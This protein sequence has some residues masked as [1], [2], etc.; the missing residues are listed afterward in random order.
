MLVYI[1]MIGWV[2]I[3]IFGF[4]WILGLLSVFVFYVYWFV[5]VYIIF[6]V[7]RL[8]GKVVG[9]LFVWG[10]YYIYIFEGCEYSS[11]C[12]LLFFFSNDNLNNCGKLFW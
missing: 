10:I 1:L 3:F 5:F 7:L 11:L 2:S 6:F 9:G 8:C 12:V 4:V